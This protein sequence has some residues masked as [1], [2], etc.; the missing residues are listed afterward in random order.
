MGSQAS[1]ARVEVAAISE[2]RVFASTSGAG[3]FQGESGCVYRAALA[4]GLPWLCKIMYGAVV[5]GGSVEELF[6]E[7]LSVNGQ[8]GFFFLVDYNVELLS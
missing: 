7:G 2:K 8:T 1:E 3:L 4:D 6:C 5:V